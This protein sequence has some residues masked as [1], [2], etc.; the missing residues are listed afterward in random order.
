MT[1]VSA[2]HVWRSAVPQSLLYYMEHTQRARGGVAEMGQEAWEVGRVNVFLLCFVT[3]ETGPEE[4][5]YLLEV[6]LLIRG[7]KFSS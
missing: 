3:D 2:G 1:G 5:S 7:E 4:F 6:Q